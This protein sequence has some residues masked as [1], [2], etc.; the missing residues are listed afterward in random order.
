MCHAGECIAEHSEL[1]GIVLHQTTFRIKGNAHVPG[2][3]HI[4][5]FL[6]IAVKHPDAVPGIFPKQLAADRIPALFRQRKASLRKESAVIK[7]IDICILSADTH[8]N[9]IR[10]LLIKPVDPLGVLN[11]REPPVRTKLPCAKQR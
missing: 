6:Q 1:T 11:G 10:I 4:Q 3:C 9:D 8:Q 5:P 7:R 2:Q